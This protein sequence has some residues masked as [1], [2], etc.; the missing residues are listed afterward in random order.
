MNYPLTIIIRH[1]R[2]NLKKCSLRG[3]EGRSDFA[4]YRYPHCATGKEDLPD[5]SGCILLDMAGEPLSHKDAQS[6]FILLD[7][8]W[9]LAEKMQNNIPEIQNLPKRSI[10]QGFV[11]AYPRRQDDCP[12]PEAG[13]AS[14]EALYIAYHAA[15]RPTDGL[16]DGYH[17][18][19]QFLE[20]N[21]ALFLK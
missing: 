1:A 15:G 16:L 18:K 10:P 6:G 4:F 3:L 19:D 2:E 8:T 21:K 5:L 17:W 14:I 12:D 11:T 7:G 9:K 20:K 13:L